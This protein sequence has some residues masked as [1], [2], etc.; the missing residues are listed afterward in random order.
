MDGSPDAAGN[1]T[2]SAREQLLPLLETLCQLAAEEGDARQSHFFGVVREGVVRARDASDL[3]G[4]FMELSTSAF[5][6]FVFSPL[7]SLLLDRVLQIAQELSATLSADGE[8][9]H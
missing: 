6:G 1:A 7:V 8:Q 2:E 5:R 4:P 9:T 3:A